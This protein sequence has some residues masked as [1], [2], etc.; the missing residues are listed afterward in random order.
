MIHQGMIDQYQNLLRMYQ[1][2]AEFMEKIG[3]IIKIY[4]K[5]GTFA[6]KE[7]ELTDVQ[8][9]S[10][11][12]T[13]QT[14][15]LNGYRHSVPIYPTQSGE[16]MIHRDGMYYYLMPWLEGKGVEKENRENELMKQIA[17]VHIVTANKEKIN[18]EYYKKYYEKAIYRAEI[19]KLDYERYIDQCEKRLY[20]SPYDLLYCTYFNLFMQME[21]F[22]LNQL[23]DWYNNVLEKTNNRI[24]ICHGNVRPSHLLY[25]ENGH[26]YLT[27]FER[28]FTA[29]PIYDLLYYFKKLFYK[30]PQFSS[31]TLQQY[32]QYNHHN[33]L[34]EDERL[35]FMYYLT[36][37]SGIYNCIKHY[38]NDRTLPEKTSVVQLQRYIWQLQAAKAFVQQLQQVIEQNRQASTEEI[39]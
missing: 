8:R 28:S 38:R 34:T 1:I 23:E 25:D 27:S 4:S 32:N 30:T 14:L 12:F 24:V 9:K 3:K 11:L 20:M 7:T 10:F 36:K 26:P 17:K 2:E 39:L 15:H 37:T 19:R 31:S 21:Q 29:S 35:L 13:I 16:Y 6:L 33:H 5:K 22:S 18:K